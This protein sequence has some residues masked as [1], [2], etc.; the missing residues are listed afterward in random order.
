MND[1]IHPART[2]S[3]D[4]LMAGLQQACSL[5]FVYP[6]LDAASGLRLFIY[7]PQCVY[8]N[9]WD[10]FSLLARGLIVDEAAGRVVATPFPKFFN[11]GERGGILPDLPFEAY[12]KVD[13]SLIIVFQ[14]DGRW[15]AATKG[16]FD[17]DQALWAQARLD[18]AD[19]SALRPGSTYLFEAVYPENRMVIRYSEAA[20]IMLAAYAED[21]LESSYDD[22]LAVSDALGWRA[23]KRHA[24]ANIPEM[25]ARAT[26][27]PRN[28][29]GFVIRFANG[30]RLKLKGAEYRRIHALIARCTPL[31][32]WDLMNAGE[33][34][35]AIRRDLPEEFWTDFDDI[36]RLLGTRLADIEQSVIAA[37]ASVAHLS[38]K[39]LGLSRDVLP[40]DMRGFVFGFRKAGSISGRT[41]GS[42]MREVRP[43]GNELPGYV[44]SYAMGRI[45]DEATS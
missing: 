12:E 37:A 31:G 10:Q 32:V 6:R 23:A 36:V 29:E 19:L 20:L 30:L 11:V 21:G 33:D 27:L 9:G 7:S 1:L 16:A 41:R 14:H 38:D 15:R 5:G 26:M 3:F 2:L 45:L 42:L 22:V 39:E 17:S 24:F 34:L 28:D 25:V 35:E 43:S 8:E 18:A 44:P 40:D 13:G 4:D